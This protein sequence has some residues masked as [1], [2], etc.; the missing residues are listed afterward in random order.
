MLA[1]APDDRPGL[2]DEVIPTLRAFASVGP[3]YAG[4]PPSAGRRPH[5]RRPGACPSQARPRTPGAGRRSTPALAAARPW[6][7]APRP[8]SPGCP[9]RNHRRPANGATAGDPAARAVPERRRP[10][11]RAHA[12]IPRRPGRDAAGGAR[13]G[14]RATRPAPHAP[15]RAAAA[16]RRGPPPGAPGG[17]RPDPP[18]DGEVRVALSSDPA[19]AV[20]C[21]PGHP[22]QARHHQRQLR[23]AHRQPADDP[24]AVS[25]RLPH[26]EGRD[27][28][29]RER[30]PLRPPAAAHR[31]RPPAPAALPLGA[32]GVARLRRAEP[33]AG[34]AGRLRVPLSIEA[35]RHGGEALSLLA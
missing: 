18:S 19:G 20:I 24:A 13:L 33:I 21:T 34:G 1:K 12:P 11:P 2:T 9:G 29:R 15:R 5:R 6:R 14:G 23:A 32:S 4:R 25:P 35:H 7:P 31:R 30:H 16:A 26:R 22:R 28:R 10:T 27:R 3:V 17:R 8:C